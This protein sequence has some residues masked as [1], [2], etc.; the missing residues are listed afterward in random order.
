LRVKRGLSSDYDRACYHIPKEQS[1][2]R[3]SQGHNFVVRLKDPELQPV[4][5]DLVYGHIKDGKAG[6]RR[7]DDSFDDPI[8]LKSDGLPTYHLANVVDDHHMEIT[9]VIRGAEWLISTRKHLILYDAFGWKPPSF[10]HVGLLLDEAGNKLSKRDKAY[11]LSAIQDNG[12]LPEALNNFLALLGWTNRASKRDFATMQELEET[13]GAIRENR[14][15]A[16]LRLNSLTLSLPK[17][18]QLLHWKNSG[19]YHPD[20][21]QFV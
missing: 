14:E 9:H 4:F 12:V 11:D 8:I 17:E 18:I 20:M 7:K 16:A 13:V 15:G 1:D 21:L 19:S 10:A 3:A 2:E 5:H 6:L